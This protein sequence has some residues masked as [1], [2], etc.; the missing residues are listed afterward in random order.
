[1]NENKNIV[2]IKIPEQ[3]RNELE[4]QLAKQGVTVVKED[5]ERYTAAQ[6]VIA[7][8]KSHQNEKFAKELLL[9]WYVGADLEIEEPI[10]IEFFSG[11]EE[12]ECFVT[13]IEIENKDIEKMI[14]DYYDVEYLTDIAQ[15]TSDKIYTEVL[16]HKS[17]FTL[18][19]EEIYRVI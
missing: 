3:K 7:D 1:M 15:G 11:V 18:T 13:E 14:L 4:T 17:K 9:E 6:E 2:I 8:Y 5:K 19:K 16:D 10:T 12:Q